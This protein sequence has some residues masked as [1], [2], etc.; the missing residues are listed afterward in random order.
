MTF[1]WQNS[2]DFSEKI[3][4]GK[5]VNVPRD[6]CLHR[7][8]SVGQRPKQAMLKLTF[9]R[10]FFSKYSSTHFIMTRDLSSDSIY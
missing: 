3:S 5:R 1:F 2:G 10:T 6:A 7:V 8:L 4:V 9:G